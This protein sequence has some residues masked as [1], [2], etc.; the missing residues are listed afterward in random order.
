L[1]LSG[2]LKQHRAFCEKPGHPDCAGHEAE[3]AATERADKDWESTLT[4]FEAL[5][6]EQKKGNARW[7]DREQLIRFLPLAKL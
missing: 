3:L 7:H 1:A 6:K 4:P 2:F 5:C